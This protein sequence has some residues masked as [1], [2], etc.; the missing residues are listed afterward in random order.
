MYNNLS[1]VYSQGKSQKLKNLI[2]IRSCDTH[3]LLQL[4]CV[5]LSLVYPKDTFVTGT[6]L[7]KLAICQ[8]FAKNCACE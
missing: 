2:S 4:A 3:Q 7:V 6:K 5:S 8:I 1:I